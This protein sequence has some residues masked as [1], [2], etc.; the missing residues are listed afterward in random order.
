[1]AT[2]SQARLI[3]LIAASG[4]RSMGDSRGSSGR[5]RSGGG[6]AAAA[7][8][9]GIAPRPFGADR[10]SSPSLMTIDAD[11]LYTMFDPP[12]LNKQ[13][14]V[15]E[16]LRVKQSMPKLCLPFTVTN[17]EPTV[18]ALDQA[19]FKEFGGSYSDS[20]S[21]LVEADVFDGNRGFGLYGDV[22]NGLDYHLW[23]LALVM[24]TEYKARPM[25]TTASYDVSAYYTLRKVGQIRL[26]PAASS[27]ATAARYAV[28]RLLLRDSVRQMCNAFGITTPEASGPGALAL[29]QL[30]SCLLE[31][32]D[33]TAAFWAEITDGPDKSP[34]IVMACLAVVRVST[35]PAT[36]VPPPPPAG[37]PAPATVSTIDVFDC[38]FSGFA[39]PNG[40]VKAL[41]LQTLF[42]KDACTYRNEAVAGA[43]AY[44]DVIKT[45]IDDNLAALV[46][47]LPPA[48]FTDLGDLL[49]L[50]VATAATG[51]GSAHGSGS[52]PGTAVPPVG[53]GSGGGDGRDRMLAEALNVTKLPASK[54]ED[55]HEKVVPLPPGFLS[56]VQADALVP[57]Q[58]LI[59]AALALGQTE[60]G[61]DACANPGVIQDIVDGVTG[62]VT[63]V[64]QSDE[65]LC[66]ALTQDIASATSTG[67]TERANAVRSLHHAQG[68]VIN[69]VTTMIKTASYGGDVHGSFQP[70]PT[71]VGNLLKGMIVGS[72]SHFV[73]ETMTERNHDYGP[74]MCVPMNETNRPRTTQQFFE[75]YFAVGAYKEFGRPMFVGEIALSAWCKV[76]DA[77]GDVF[78]TAFRDDCLEY[79]KSQNMK[80]QRQLEDQSFIDLFLGGIFKLDLLN[81]T[82]QR[83]N[84]PSP[85]PRLN[86]V[87]NG[88]SMV[89]PTILECITADLIKLSK[90][91]EA[92]SEFQ[93]LNMVP[94]MIPRKIRLAQ[95]PTPNGGRS[96]RQGAQL[97]IA[98]PSGGAVLQGTELQLGDG[99]RSALSST[100]Q[101]GPA[102][103]GRDGFATL[104]PSPRKASV[105][106]D[107]ELISSDDVRNLGVIPLF[108]SEPLLAGKC[109]A[110]YIKQG[111]CTYPKCMFCLR[112][113]REA[114]SIDPKDLAQ[115]LRR[116]IG[117]TSARSRPGTPGDGRKR[118][119]SAGSASSVGSQNSDGGGHKPKQ[120]RR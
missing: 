32:T 2:P 49:R 90:D 88:L 33:S 38:F 92:R 9:A 37:P 63:K 18:M 59:Q 43:G 98:F 109:V 34:M 74:W 112:A 39:P 41:A 12:G 117:S 119:D 40:S 80:C 8:T 28:T 46:G 100:S 1:M 13:W 26:A 53:G 66:W 14:T 89:S 67:G 10:T 97:E 78:M 69:H 86:G 60:A 6:G 87:F 95:S 16:V 7:A 3:T 106:P 82:Y 108:K 104:P 42:P 91:S 47:K 44:D 77:C 55:G 111:G 113:L 81:A 75:W 15:N 68:L 19:V 115:A 54:G 29:A 61:A 102:L 17:P 62:R 107:C 4:K 93:I 72:R 56:V 94:N 51:T 58:P 103:P 70:T 118:S 20:T 36:G 79:I 114:A 11:E 96:S 27:E 45:W 120:H 73:R 85:K 57:K 65:T 71:M 83:G 35:R 31:E 23:A 25:N 48:P 5:K 116:T 64:R 22:T 52:G 50:L 21:A 110:L 99:R 101:Y 105:L 84:T 30:D 76:I 24:N